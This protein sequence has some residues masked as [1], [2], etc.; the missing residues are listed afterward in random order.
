M[1]IVNSAQEVLKPSNYSANP[2]EASIRRQA[3][4]LLVEIQ[5][6]THRIGYTLKMRDQLVSDH[7]KALMQVEKRE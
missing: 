7:E 4:E 3:A 5:V 6:L 1:E 2:T